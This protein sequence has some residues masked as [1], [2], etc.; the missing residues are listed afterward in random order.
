[1][2][3]LFEENMHESLENK[4]NEEQEIEEILHRKLVI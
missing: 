1:M 4:D 3:E 2:N